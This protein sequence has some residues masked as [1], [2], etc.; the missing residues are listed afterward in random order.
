M[1]AMIR[2]N[3]SFVNPPGGRF[4]MNVP[5]MIKAIGGLIMNAAGM[6]EALEARGVQVLL[7]LSKVEYMKAM[8]LAIPLSHAAKLEDARI[9]CGESEN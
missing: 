6:L 4:G 7:H 8:L 9:T 3:K 5:W 2:K 1:F